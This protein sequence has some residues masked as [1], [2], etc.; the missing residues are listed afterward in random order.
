MSVAEI[1]GGDI[2]SSDGADI[3]GQLGASSGG[4]G[5]WRQQNGENQNR[6]TEQNRGPDAWMT[7]MEHFVVSSSVALIIF[8]AGMV[9][10]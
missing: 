9:Q 4:G 10:K 8:C 1:I 3:H 2:S 6:G 7:S 5:T